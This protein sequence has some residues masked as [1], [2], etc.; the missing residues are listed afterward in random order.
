[1][2]DPREPVDTGELP[3]VDD[4]IDLDPPEDLEE[5]EEP[6][7]NLEAETEEDE[8]AEPERQPRRR[9]SDTI[10]TLRQRSQ[11]A[12]RELA[13]LRQQFNEFRTRPVVQPIDPQAAARA[14]QA[15]YERI[16]ML[17]PEQQLQAMRE[18]GRRDAALAQFQMHDNLD[19]RDFNALK[20]ADA[21]AARLAP[22]VEV[23]LSRLRAQGIYTVGRETIF[24]ALYGQEIRAK[25][26]ARTGR[27]RQNGAR[28]VAR[29][30]TRPGNG[31]GDV[32]RTGGRR[33]GENADID[34]LRSTPASEWS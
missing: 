13:D 16:A 23:E 28:N 30:T 32:A 18:M 5:G 10:R 25:A 27:E 9:S 31:R 4:E 20:R 29:V 34:L 24:N 19:A 14:E 11:A 6:E 26:Q 12:E 21:A 2:S 15:E 33:G 22:Q 3:P 7:A 17:A 1:V 8:D